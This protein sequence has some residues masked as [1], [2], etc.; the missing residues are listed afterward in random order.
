MKK[1]VCLL[2]AVSLII[3]CFVFPI[4]AEETNVISTAV[5]KLK[6]NQQVE[7]IW[8]PILPDG[9]SVNRLVLAT[10]GSYYYSVNKMIVDGFYVERIAFTN[11][12]TP[13]DSGSLLSPYEA[14]LTAKNVANPG[15]IAPEYAEMIQPD[16]WVELT[17]YGTTTAY[18]SGYGYLG[19]YLNYP[20]IT[21]PY[22]YS[23]TN[24]G[25]NK[26]GVCRETVIQLSDHTLCS[27]LYHFVGD[28]NPPELAEWLQTYFPLGFTTMGDADV[29][30]KVDSGDALTILKH[31][32]GKEQVNESLAYTMADYDTNG[33]LS[34]SD[35]LAALKI[36]V[37][38]LYK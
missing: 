7:E 1:T 30:G 13:D 21:V 10:N 27:V 12:K 8:A 14:L 33:I 6:L 5:P 24:Q 20:T 22:Y 25:N 31:V 23:Q 11:G 29:N 4:Q 26:T 36:A 37:G 19:T 16:E 18:M 28:A 9:F 34:A 35:A 2:V 38:I 32:V 3:S 15:T 17:E